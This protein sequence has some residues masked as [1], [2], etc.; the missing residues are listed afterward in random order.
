MNILPYTKCFL[1]KFVTAQ[2]KNVS[3]QKTQHFLQSQVRVF[4]SK[5][6]K[7]LTPEMLKMAA[8]VDDNDEKKKKKKDNEIR[9][10]LRDINGNVLGLKTKKE[11]EQIAHKNNWILVDDDLSKKTKTMRLVD[12]REQLKHES[13]SENEKGILDVDHGSNKD[14]EK[15]RS[16]PKHLFF[17]AKLSEH[18]LQVKINHIKKWISQGQETMIK[19]HSPVENLSKIVNVL[20]LL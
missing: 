14:D 15:H 7:D 20:I 4:S 11:A 5:K 9:I 18:D 10:N 2:F 12:P 6:D 19:I 13:D 3:V 1:S 8:G 16:E 17:S